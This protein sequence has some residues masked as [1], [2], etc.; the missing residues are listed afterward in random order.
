MAGSTY[1]EDYIM[2]TLKDR[3]YGKFTLSANVI[4]KMDE[5]GLAAL[6]QFMG[7]IL[8]FRAEHMFDN[9]VIVY[10]GWSPKYFKEIPIGQMVPVY[11]VIIF[12][13]A[14]PDPENDGEYLDEFTYRFEVEEGV[15]TESLGDFS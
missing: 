13:E 4:G 15:S 9:D 2:A 12:K 1:N 3:H 10:T 14:V 6:S 7:D 8:I 5:A 11:T